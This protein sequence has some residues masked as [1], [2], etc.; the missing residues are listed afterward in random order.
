[1]AYLFLFI[2]HISLAQTAEIPSHI[3]TYKM[4]S[5]IYNG[6]EEQGSGSFNAY[7]AS[8][9]VLDAAWLRLLFDDVNLGKNSYIIITSLED[10]KWQ[11]LNATSV[12]QWQLSSAYFNGN[13]VKIELY[14][15]PYDE[16][17]FFSIKEV[18]VGEFIG[19]DFSIES[20]CGPTDDRVLS[21]HPATGRLMTVGCT[22][23]IIPNGNFVTA[24]H[25]LVNGGINV[26][27][28]QVPP[29]L[30]DGTPQNPGPEDQYAVNLSTSVFVADGIG[31]DWGTFEVFSNSVTGLFPMEAQGAV[32]SIAQNLDPDSIRITGYG[33]D[34]GADNKTQQTHVGANNGSSETTMRYLTDTQGGNSGSPV[35]DEATGYAVG[36]H[37]HGGCNTNGF[38]IGTSLFNNAFWIAVDQGIG[39]CQTEEAFNPKPVQGKMEVSINIPELSWDNGIAA[40]SNELYFGTEPGNLNLVQSGSLA[41]SWTI[42]ERPLS[43]NTIYYWQVVENGDSCFTKGPSWSFAT[44]QDPAIVSKFMDDFES[45][46]SN[47]TITNNGGNCDWTVF[48]PPYP[49]SYTLPITSSGQVFAT[50]S[51]DCGMGT[52]LE[53]TATLNFVTDASEVPGY[54]IVFVEWDNDW[55]IFDAE[56][57]AHVEYSLDGGNT[58]STLVSWIGGEQRNTHEVHI[59]PNAG[60]QPDIRFRFRS[61]QPGWDW[62]WA[63][64]NFAVYLTNPIPVELNSFDA[65]LKENNVIL[66]WATATETNN[67]GFEVQRS[68]KGT[69]YSK[70]AFIEGHGTVIEKQKYSYS[71]KNLEVG[72]YSYRL[73]QIDFDG[74]SELSSVIEVEILAPKV[75]SLEQNYPNPFNPST[76]IKFSL[77]SDSKLTLTVFDVLGQEVV[78]LVDG[79]LPAGAH[80]IDFNATKIHSGVYIYRIDAT[81]IDGTNFTSVMKMILI[82]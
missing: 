4:T 18:I 16:N 2:P 62:W 79:N 32:W 21:N 1:M 29:S 80:D 72:N 59:V 22:G 6:L 45:E 33:A 7:T 66:S 52:T 81:G 30:P 55:R 44:E 23:W 27:Q 73:K 58:W 54:N 71:D 39:N 17:I 13:Q 68:I 15:T 14:V 46:I 78:K 74:T 8:L 5:G 28:F 11:K 57:E 24:G 47:W 35:I 43:Y 26:V 75:Y 40:I 9:Q 48:V 76:K 36:V 10:G 60:L 67:M 38:N 51:D 82:K 42:M 63:V 53:S 64:D 70:I 12:V 50:D 34:S 69:D 56:D 20:Q 3:E 41:S 61:V 77:A 31:N 65:T 25:C 19:D 37:T 49:N